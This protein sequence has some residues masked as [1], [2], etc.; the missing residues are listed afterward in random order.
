MKCAFLNLRFP[1]FFLISTFV[2]LLLA[3][4]LNAQSDTRP[5]VVL[6]NGYNDC[7]T[8]NLSS[9]RPYMQTVE[10]ELIR[11]GAEFRLVP[12]D[13]FRDGSGERSST[14]NDAAFLSEAA[15]YINN[16]LDPNRPLILIGH[17]F[18][19]DSLLK[20]APRINRRIQFLGVIDPV[21]TGGFREPV[22]RY[23]VPANVDYFFNRWQENALASANVVPF[24]SRLVSG[25]VSGCNASYCDQDVQNLSRRADGSDIRISCEAWEITC[26]GYQPWPGGSNGTKARRLLHNEMPLDEYIQRQMANRISEIINWS[27]APRFAVVCIENRTN[28][29]IS[30]SY[31]WG[32]ESW[33]TR[34][35]IGGNSRWHS[36]RYSLGSRN[37]PNFSIRF[38]YSFEPGYQE[39]S[40]SLVRYSAHEEG[41]REAKT[42]YFDYRDQSRSGIGL[43]DSGN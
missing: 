19:G 40:F 15:E 18:G 33:Q 3:Q 34:E 30:Y 35:I 27:D 22:T 2:S 10:N 36:R 21:A 32:N 20:L 28:S 4:N 31:R 29:N 39:E 6:V 1:L 5:Y 43:F 12:W 17:S 13:T 38:D 7:C 26:P 37:S 24:D 9:R 23:G 14:S 11:H 8:W 42:Y 16:R 25:R 41:C